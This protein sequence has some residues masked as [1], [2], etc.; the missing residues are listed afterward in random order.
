MA[1]IKNNAFIEHQDR[2]SF[3]SSTFCVMMRSRRVNFLRTSVLNKVPLIGI[4]YRINEHEQTVN[5]SINA[6]YL[7]A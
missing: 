1:A 2:I 6:P 5:I 3:F 7:I 4:I